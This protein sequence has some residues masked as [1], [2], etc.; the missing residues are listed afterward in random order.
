[1]R[2]NSR[3][4][5]ASPATR[6]RPPA[7][8][9]ILPTCWLGVSVYVIRIIHFQYDLELVASIWHGNQAFNALFGAFGTVVVQKAP[10]GRGDRRMETVLQTQLLA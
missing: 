2:L 5:R 3:T 7:A 6:F 9:L 10:A 1:M 4:T 8:L